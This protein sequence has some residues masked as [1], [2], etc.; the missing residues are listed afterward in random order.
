LQKIDTAIDEVAACTAATHACIAAVVGLRR[1]LYPDAP[2]HQPPQMAPAAPQTAA[3]EVAG[4][5]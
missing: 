3:G 1:T 2:P 5:T 4:V